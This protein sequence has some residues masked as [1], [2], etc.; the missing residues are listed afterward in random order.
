MD[1]HYFDC[2]CMLGPR[3]DG[4]PGEPSSLL[5]LLENMEYFGI[6]DA[7]VTSATSRDYSVQDGNMELSKVLSD[8]SQLSM[9]WTL[10][11]LPCMRE[12]NQSMTMMDDF[13]A[14]AVVAY[15]KRHKYSLAPW[16]LGNWLS[17]QESRKIPLLIPRDQTEWDEIQTLCQDYPALPIIVTRVGYRELN[18]L[19]PLWKHYK[20]LFIDISW[21]S[22]HRGLESIADRGFVDQLIFGTFYPYYTPGGALGILEY[23]QLEISEK[24]K[25]AYETL[26]GLI[27]PGQR[28]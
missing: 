16:S 17:I 22:I 15:P 1:L 13:G 25:I 2:N 9:V 11:S 26:A 18:Y 8:H 6:Q 24:N 20:N 12:P 7:L 10:D 28:S 23:A 21:L 27:F 3:S 14:K 5:Q 19:Y 4:K